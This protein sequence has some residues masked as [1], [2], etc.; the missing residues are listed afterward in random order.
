MNEMIIEVTDQSG[1]F[2]SNIS[3]NSNPEYTIQVVPQESTCELIITSGNISQSGVG[4]DPSESYYITGTWGFNKITTFDDSI[5]VQ[6]NITTSSY[7][8]A[9][10]WN[11]AYLHSQIVVGNPHNTDLNSLTD[12]IITGPVLDQFLTYDGNNW[13]NVTKDLSGFNYWTKTGNDL[14]YY[15]GNVGI[16]AT[17]TT[18]DSSILQVE[19]QDGKFSFLSKKGSYRSAGI[20]HSATEGGILYAYD[21]LTSSTTKVRLSAGGDSYFMGGDVGFGTSSPSNKVHITQS[22]HSPRALYI[23]KAGEEVISNSTNYS[24]VQ[25]IYQ[26]TNYNINSGVTDSG[27]RMG[28]DIVSYVN[29]GLFLGTLA[30]QYGIRVQY[31]HATGSGTGTI[32]NVYGINLAYNAAGNS[33]V[34]NNYSIYSSG[35]GRMWH[36]GNMGVGVDPTSAKFQV[37]TASGD[38]VIFDTSA[39]ISLITRYKRQGTEY[40]AIY[41]VTGGNDFYIRATSASGKLYLSGGNGSQQV[42]VDTAGKFGVGIVSPVSRTHIYSSSSNTGI[43][44]GVTIEQA[45]TG[46]SILQYYLTGGQRYTTGIDNSDS[47]KFKIG[48]G[49]DWANGVD[50]SI[51]TTGVVSISNLTGYIKGASGALSAVASIPVTDGG[52][53]LSTIGS[54]NHILGVN[55]AGAALEYKALEGTNITVTH[56]TGEIYISIP[57]NVSTTSEVTFAKVT[58]TAAPLSG[59]DLANKS[60]VDSIASGFKPKQACKLAT[61]T[62]IASLSGNISVDGITT[63]AGDRILVKDQSTA[64]AN[65]IYVAS[66]SAWSRATDMDSWDSEVPGALVG[67]TNGTANANTTWVCN[68]T[69]GGTLNSTSITFVLY[70]SGNVSGTTNRITV[71]SSV[72][73]I[74]ANYVGQTSITTLGTIS[75]GSWNAT[76]IP[77]SKGGTGSAYTTFTGPTATRTYTLPDATATL[78]YSGGALGTPSSGVATNLTGTATGLTAGAA[79]ILSTARA[80]YGNNFDGSAALTQIIASTYG[81]TGNGFTKFLGPTTAEKTFILPDFNATLLYEMGPL[82]TPSSGDFSTGTFTWPATID[83]DITGS[84]ATLNTSRN[85]A[86]TGDLTWNVNFD[87]STNVTAAGTI[88]NSAVSLAKMANVATATVFY[89]KTAGTGAPEVQTL[90]TLKT[91]L[92][93]TGTNSGDQ[94]ITLTGNVTGSG[95]GS[96]AT[97]IANRAVTLAKMANVATATVFYRKTAGTGAPEV[98]TLATLKTDLGLTGTNS[99]DQTSISGITGTKSQYNVSLTDGN[100]MFVGDAPTSHSHGAITNAGYFTSGGS[101]NFNS[102]STVTATLFGDATSGYNT[103]TINIGTGGDIYSNTVIRLGATGVVSNSLYFSGMGVGFLKTD[104]NGLVTRNNYTTLAGFGITDAYT[105]T[106]VD[107]N[108]QP[109]NIYLTGLSGSGFAASAGLV[110]YND[111]AWTLD[112]NDYAVSGHSITS[113][114]ATAWRMFYSNATTTAIQQLAFGASG[115]M[116]KSTGATSAPVWSATQTPQALTQSGGALTWNVA[117]GFNA[118]VTLT[119]NIT[120]FNFSGAVAGDSGVLTVIQDAT[121]SRTMVLPSG[122]LKESGSLTLSTAANSKDVLGWYY[123]GVNYFWNIGKAFV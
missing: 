23:I 42:T 37:T 70:S 18:F 5:I 82:G 31:G 66:A 8:T 103:K 48:R 122:H 16:G 115:S 91:D 99:G 4:F 116:L 11:D 53:G 79:A 15:G 40:G 34:T 35:S 22:E 83:T 60:Y 90:A 121:G 64:S 89:R 51:S 88:A 49:D 93:L 87:G 63:A 17:P 39:A 72:I 94:T 45:S 13:V 32:T 119:A 110:R 21:G 101:L 107:A 68:N 102:T 61:T 20:Y 113:H 33:T 44:A 97:T 123:D 26:N 50:F 100:F 59:S 19:A 57:Q 54:S 10:N 77:V 75:T 55:A 38:S 27:Y 96:F 105:K 84:A 36:V 24:I 95:T 65:G 76:A 80:I 47:D 78:L 41:S 28:L 86:I 111:N 92:G 109:L 29:S 30:A 43:Y 46:D 1:N 9:I 52:T 58:V 69:T 74:S 67:I 112:A 62:N 73:D 106:Y 71:T 85:I 7:G 25:S 12:V 56:T 108:F 3:L 114:G 14:S 104:A 2:N 120:T 118:R 98:Q 6:N 117:N 81:G